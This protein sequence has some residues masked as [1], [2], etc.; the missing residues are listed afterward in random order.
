MQNRAIF[1]G[2]AFLS[3]RMKSRLTINHGPTIPRQTEYDVFNAMLASNQRAEI[4]A[5]NHD[6]SA[7]QIL[8][9]TKSERTENPSGKHYRGGV[10]AKFQNH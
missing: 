1:G 2:G 9:G 4:P 5:S 8:A 7:P 10:I 3:Y 6:S